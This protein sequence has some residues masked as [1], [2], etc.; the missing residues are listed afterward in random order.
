VDAI[1]PLCLDWPSIPRS[2]VYTSIGRLYLDRTC[3]RGS[4]LVQ[5]SMTYFVDG[6]Y[7]VTENLCIIVRYPHVSMGWPTCM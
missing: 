3:D 7:S 4:K 6:P 2:A 5:N 1:G